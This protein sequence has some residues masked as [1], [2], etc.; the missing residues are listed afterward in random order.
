MRLGMSFAESF[1]TEFHIFCY[2]V[3]TEA[4]GRDFLKT[5]LS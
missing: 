5:Q 3:W 1:Q 2:Q 4:I